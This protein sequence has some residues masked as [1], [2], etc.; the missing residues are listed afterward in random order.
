MRKDINIRH[1]IYIVK[2]H[3]AAT[4]RS[5][6]IQNVSIPPHAKI[7]CLAAPSNLRHLR[8]LL[9]RP[10]SLLHPHSLF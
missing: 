9:L 4:L 7:P 8:D 6:R 5:S 10:P 3:G 1:L 2:D